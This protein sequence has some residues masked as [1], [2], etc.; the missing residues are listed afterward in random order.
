MFQIGKIFE[1]DEGDWGKNPVIIRVD[2]PQ[3]LRI[4][5]G[6]ELGAWTKYYI[7]VDLLE[8]KQKLL[9][10]QSLEENIR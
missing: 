3:H 6:N 5:D 8:I 4:P 1:M 9:L 7:P 2:D 10:I